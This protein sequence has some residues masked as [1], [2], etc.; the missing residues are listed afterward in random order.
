MLPVLDLIYFSKVTFLSDDACSLEF[1]SLQNY[2]ALDS[3]DQPFYQT[4]SLNSRCI[5]LHK[6]SNV[7]SIR[8]NSLFPPPRSYRRDP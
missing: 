5:A 2:V 1:I 4:N 3:T 7:P 8:Q 6:D